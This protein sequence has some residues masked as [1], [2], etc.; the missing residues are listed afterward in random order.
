MARYDLHSAELR[1]SYS[2]SETG[3]KVEC[4]FQNMH[5]DSFPCHKVISGCA[6]GHY[7]PLKQHGQVRIKPRFVIFFG[8]GRVGRKGQ[9]INL[10][11]K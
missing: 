4:V 8:L 3:T 11:R 6:K 1:C 2:M 7:G 10:D 9:D 5:E